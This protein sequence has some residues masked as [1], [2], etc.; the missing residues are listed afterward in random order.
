MPEHLDGGPDFAQFIERLMD[1]GY[2]TFVV[3]ALHE[4]GAVFNVRRSGRLRDTACRAQEALVKLQDYPVTVWLSADL[5]SAGPH[6]SRRFGALASRNRSWLMK[7]V[8]G[9][10]E[11]LEDPQTQGL[12]CWTTLDF[13][14]F[15]ANMLV[16]IVEGYAIDGLLLDISSLPRTTENP[17]TW[18]QFGFSSLRRMQKELGIDGEKFL[19]HPTREKFQEIETWRI[20]Q[21]SHF[22]QSLKM[23]VCKV[24][25]TLPFMM[26]VDLIDEEQPY[27]PWK[28]LFEDGIVEEVAL[29][30]APENI[31]THLHALDEAMGSHRPVLA[32]ARNEGDLEI[33][34]QSRERMSSLGVCVTHP[35]YTSPIE[36]PPAK[37]SW[38]MPGS[39]ERH[40]LTAGAAALIHLS[41]HVM[42]GTPFAAY[43]TRLKDFLDFC[44]DKIKYEDVLVIR[45]D[46]LFLRKEINAKHIAVD[47]ERLLAT[48]DL[49]TRL[50]SLMPAPVMAF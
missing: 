12:F 40:P 35:V 44:G 25:Q 14:R 34:S 39:L 46:L 37:I 6:G 7:N 20:D 50:F 30:T 19:T 43:V 23:R 41:R 48:L 10:H 9:G 47:D 3:P 4:G 2:N 11:V 5:L 38:S 15:V 45:D 32:T 29:C 22:V 16:D 31:S 26:M 1:A 13:R 49:A 24:R 8:D 33:L 28:R 36:F 18:M 42:A 21:L 17:R 27:L